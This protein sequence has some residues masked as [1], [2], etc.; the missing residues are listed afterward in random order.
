MVNTNLILN[1]VNL[2]L[3]SCQAPKPPARRTR[4]LEVVFAPRMAPLDHK[5]NDG[6]WQKRWADAGVFRASDAERSRPKAYIL[7]MF[8]YPS[9]AGLHVGHPEGY[10]ATDIVTRF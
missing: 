5:A 6:K 1:T 10:T 8:P 3:L 9:G 7:D 2:T 4:R